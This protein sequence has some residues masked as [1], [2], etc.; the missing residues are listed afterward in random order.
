MALYNLILDVNVGPETLA[1]GLSVSIVRVNDG[2]GVGTTYTFAIPGPSTPL[3]TTPVSVPL[4]GGVSYFMDVQGGQR[5]G[6]T[7]PSAD[8]HWADITITYPT[9]GPPPTWTELFDQLAAAG[10]IK[11]DI[12]LPQTPLVSGSYYTAA[13]TGTSTVQL[14]ESTMRGAR[15]VAGRACTINEIGVEVATLGSAGALVRL[16]LYSLAPAT[17]VLTRLVDG[18]TVSATTT[19]YKSVAVSQA[20]AKGDQLVAVAVQQGAATTRAFYRSHTGG[21]PYFGDAT[22]LTV[23]GNILG[24]FST[25]AVAGALPLNPSWVGAGSGG[26]PRVLIKAA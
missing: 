7:M 3:T 5:Y 18:G 16:G 6:F 8:T 22:A 17:G 4:I 20:V 9:S 19:G 26:V 14:A 24:G 2:D 23:S 25:G 15:I 10:F 1:S 12:S 11:G 21:D 13:A